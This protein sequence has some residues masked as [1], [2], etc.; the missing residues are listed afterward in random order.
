MPRSNGVARV[1]VM[2]GLVKFS[3]IA[4]PPRDTVIGNP[5]TQGLT[6][7]E[8]LTGNPAMA[9]SPTLR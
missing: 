4:L 7:M 9:T 6:L 5:E 3:D 2:L 1:M 8:A